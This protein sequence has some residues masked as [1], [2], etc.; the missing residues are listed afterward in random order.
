MKVLVTYKLPKEGLK[1]L[2]EKHDVTYPEKDILTVE[3]MLKI[4]HRF[5]AVVTVFGKPF[6]DSVMKRGV[7]L[8][9]IS[10]YGGGVDNINLEL[11]RKL[12]ITVTNTPNAVTEPTA[13]LAMGLML[14]VM[15]GISLSDRKLRSQAGLEWGIMKNLGNTLSGKTLGII[16]MGKIGKAVAGRAISFGMK[17]Y[18]HNRNKVDTDTEKQL[19]TSLLSLNNLLEIS[20][21]ISIHTPLTDETK[22]LIGTKEFEI[23][24]ESVFIINTARGPVIDENALINALKNNEI[25]GAGLDVFENEPDISPGL[26]KLDNV[27]L[28]PHIGTGTYE[29]RIEI[30]IVAA[31]NIIDYFDGKTPEFRLDNGTSIWRKK[32][33][34]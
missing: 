6:P 4:I 27:V 22:H 29:T 21:V 9:I 33:V 14:S 20:D 31:K 7:N 19:N 32:Q 18:Y 24:K 12:R 13:E 15:R 28:A 30:G 26:L 2:F 5:D 16:C 17:V 34:K 3:E 25:K 1:L 8:K 10:N 23:M 11:A